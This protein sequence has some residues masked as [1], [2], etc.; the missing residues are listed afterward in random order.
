M[1]EEWLYFAEVGA[2]SDPKHQEISAKQPQKNTQPTTPIGL[3]LL[4]K[5]CTI[6]ASPWLRDDVMKK[7]S[8]PTHRNTLRSRYQTELRNV[9]TFHN[10][11]PNNFFA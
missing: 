9:L 10:H 7:L 4:T 8:P 6:V 3:W 5:Q 1:D 2:S 11:I